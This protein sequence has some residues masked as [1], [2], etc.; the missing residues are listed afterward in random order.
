MKLYAVRGF[1]NDWE[2]AC[3]FYEHRLGLPLTFKD[4]ALGW[5]EFDLGGAAWP[6]SVTWR[7]TSSRF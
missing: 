2:H 1:V 7:A 4:A 6:I 3:Q 5:A